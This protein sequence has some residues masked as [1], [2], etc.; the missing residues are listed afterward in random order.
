MRF[1]I[2]APGSRSPTREGKSLS[3]PSIVDMSKMDIVGG[4]EKTEEVLSKAEALDV[5]D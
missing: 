4:K 2:R 3:L 5:R 1:R